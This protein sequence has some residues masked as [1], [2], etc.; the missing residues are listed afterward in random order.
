MINMYNNIVLTGGSTMMPGFKE[1]FENEIIRIAEQTAKVA[2]GLTKVAAPGSIPVAIATRHVHLDAPA[3]RTLFGEGTEL[4]RVGGRR[5][6]ALM[7]VAQKGRTQLA[8]YMA[9]NPAGPG[10]TNFGA[11]P[12]GAPMNFDQV[13]AAES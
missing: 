8:N 11:N 12:Q 5:Q 6:S 1:R 9:A 7:M 4:E 2:G 3:L 13:K 10:N